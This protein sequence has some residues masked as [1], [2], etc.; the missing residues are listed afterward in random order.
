MLRTRITV[1]GLAL[2]VCGFFQ[3]VSQE[4]DTAFDVIVVDEEEDKKDDTSIEIDLKELGIDLDGKPADTTKT[5]PPTIDAI[6]LD[7]G[8][9]E[10]AE[11]DLGQ[12]IEGAADGANVPVTRA[13]VI[14]AF[15]VVAES[16]P[17]DRRRLVD[18]PQ[19]SDIFNLPAS[20]I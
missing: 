8:E 18:L 13:E 2:L 4:D 15:E 12:L 10:D 14:S 20:P 7:T 5:E 9:G 16:A 1:L 17:L 3:A 19:F 11:T 6:D